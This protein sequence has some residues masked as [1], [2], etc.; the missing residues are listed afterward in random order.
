MSRDVLSSSVGIPPETFKL[1]SAEES[2]GPSSVAAVSLASAEVA[3]PPVAIAET[4]DSSQTE[5]DK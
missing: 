3:A 5:H 1:S 2:S 4:V